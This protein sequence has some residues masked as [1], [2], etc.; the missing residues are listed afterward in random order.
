V[1]GRSSRST[2][3]RHVAADE[4]K[5]LV[6]QQRTGQQAGLAEDLEAVA[7][8]EHE[9]A[10]SGELARRRRRRREARD[11]AAAEVVAVRE[12]AG[13][14]DR[15][16]IR[17]LVLLVPDRNRLRVERR[18]AQ[19]ASRSSC[20]PGYVIDPDPRLRAANRSRPRT[21]RSAGSRAAARTSARPAPCRRCRVGRLDLEVDHLARRARPA[22]RSRGGRG[23]SRRPRPADRGCPASA[24]R[25]RW[26]SS[27]HHRRIAEVRRE[28]DRRSAARTP[29]CTSPRA[30]RRSRPELRAGI[31]LVPAVV[32]Q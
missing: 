13:Q 27:E 4:A 7:D 23:P 10:R 19:R 22:P 24:A 8:P 17:Q 18:E 20:E 32:S 5:R 15:V 2:A 29:R 9:P 6:P 21:T 31:R 14:D 30:L 25:G 16:E 28:R 26:P 3:S 12:A 1:K 11:R